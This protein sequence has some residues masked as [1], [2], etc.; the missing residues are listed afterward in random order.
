MYHVADELASATV[1]NYTL[2]DYAPTAI[3]LHPLLKYATILGKPLDNGFQVVPSARQI[4]PSTGVGGATV[5][6]FYAIV[7]PMSKVALACTRSLP[8]LTAPTLSNVIAVAVLFGSPSAIVW[9]TI[10]PG[11]LFPATVPLGSTK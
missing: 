9:I 7:P 10:I 1:I 4:M 2:S 8:T 3:A 6:I 11:T 5:N